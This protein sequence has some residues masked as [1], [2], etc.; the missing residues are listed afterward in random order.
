MK[1]GYTGGGEAFVVLV[2]IV[3]VIFVG[4][5]FTLWA[6]QKANE[7]AGWFEDE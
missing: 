6:I 3:C 5:T 4:V 2:V 1:E 7:K